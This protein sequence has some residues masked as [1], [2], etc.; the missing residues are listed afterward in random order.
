MSIISAPRFFHRSSDWSRDLGLSL[1]TRWWWVAFSVL[2]FIA[3]YTYIIAGDGRSFHV[4]ADSRVRS[5]SIVVSIISR[6][7]CV[8]YTNETTVIRHVYNYY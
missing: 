3:I 8:V 5:S 2:P 6:E 4:S 1:P 7:R